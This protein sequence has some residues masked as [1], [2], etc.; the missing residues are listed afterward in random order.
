[1]QAQSAQFDADQVADYETAGW[2]AY[3][4]REWPRLLRLTVALCQEQ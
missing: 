2:R 1:M 3:Y 4:D